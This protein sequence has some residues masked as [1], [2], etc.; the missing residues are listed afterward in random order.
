MMSK[1]LF[2]NGS[3]FKNSLSAE[4]ASHPGI[5]HIYFSPYRPQANGRIG[6]PHNFLKKKYIRKFTKKG[7]VQ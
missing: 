2:D 4:I 5:K 3:G 1:L 6:A 7:K